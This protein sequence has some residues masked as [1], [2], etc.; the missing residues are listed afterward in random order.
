[1]FCKRKKKFS[2]YN[3]AYSFSIFSASILLAL[4]FNPSKIMGI[5]VG[6]LIFV[7]IMFIHE[8][9]HFLVGLYYGFT[10]EEFSIFLGPRIFSFYIK[11]IK[12]SLK[13]IPLG[14]SVQFAG[15]YP[16]EGKSQDQISEKDSPISSDV[17]ESEAVIKN[18]G[19]F[20]V[21]PPSQR[22]PVVFAGPF[23]NIVSAFLTLCVLFSLTGFYSNKIEE[24]LKD[25][26]VIQSPISSGM[27]ILK[28]NDVTI[29]NELDLK[30]SLLFNA[31]KDLN[32]VYQDLND[33]IKTATFTSQYVIKK[34]LGIKLSV[35]GDRI[36]IQNLSPEISGK[37]ELE[38]NDILLKID[39]KEV[40]TDN[41]ID[42]LNA[43]PAER[44]EVNVEVQRAGQNLQL[45]TTLIEQKVAKSL[46]I[47]LA[48]EHSLFSAVPAAFNYTKSIITMSYKSLAQ[49]VSGKL[50]AKENLSGP[51]G[52]VSV[53]TDVSTASIP[54]ADR[55][56][57]LTMIFVLISVSLG[58]INL[59]PIPPLDGYIILSSV[60]EWIKGKPISLKVQNVLMLMGWGFFI[61]LFVMGFYFDLS[62][63]LG[64]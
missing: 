12:F 49:M 2:L 7:I 43:L 28:I 8:M 31:G 25:S 15:E 36:H 39:G 41:I 18:E 22:I 48:K 40:N 50:S 35:Q 21:K 4:S 55:I 46:G 30:S 23:V 64:R 37:S 57:S 51:L 29:K 19:D 6:L 5:L 63:L 14:A 38:P 52:I 24:V 13:S 53:I 61:I 59:L 17:V 45:K 60:V 11:G 44:S 9:G 1:M 58:I 32:I 62:R 3:T 10:I 27:K 47:V 33:E 34:R 56:S 16:E 42:I 54:L 20:Y 26:A